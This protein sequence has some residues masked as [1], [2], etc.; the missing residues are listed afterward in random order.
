MTRLSI[1]RSAAIGMM[2]LSSAFFAYLVLRP[3]GLGREE[4]PRYYQL[5]TYTLTDQDGKAFGSAQLQ[6]KV[7]VASFIFSSCRNSCPMIMAQ[8]KRLSSLLDAEH[9]DLHLVSITVDPKRDS[10]QA[11]RR[12]AHDLGADTKRWAFLTGSKQQLKQVIV[13]GY[14]VAAEPG[15]LS[16][17]ERGLPDI[18]HST[19][20]MVVDKQGYVRGLHDGTLASSVDAV[21]VQVEQLLK[22]AP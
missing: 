4:L 6:G 5:P 9:P 13:G 22:E 11:L 20:L 17:D 8:L 7:H 16:V 21:R 3:G 2:I 19:R 18:P 15:D 12:Y 14:K 10:P 1:V